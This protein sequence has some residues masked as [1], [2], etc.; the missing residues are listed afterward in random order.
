[1]NFADIITL[2]LATVLWF[3]VCTILTVLIHETGHLVFGKVSGYRLT[4]FA[5]AGLMIRNGRVQKY[6]AKRLSFGQCFMC[7][8]NIEQDPGK[9]IAGGCI[10]N[11]I[12]GS[13]L[14]IAAVITLELGNTGGVWRLM[15]IS[16]PALI[17]IVMGLTNLCGGSPMSDGNTLKD[18]REPGG[19]AMYN[20][21]MVI[22]AHIL[23]GKAFSEMPEELFK[24][25]GNKEKCS[26]TAELSMY[27]YY[28][29]FEKLKDLDGF[30]KLM[31]RHGFDRKPEH[32][33]IFAEEEDL[34]RKIW[35]YVSGGGSQYSEI[36][37]AD[38]KTPRE[39]LVQ[40][41]MSRGSDKKFEDAASVLGS[42]MYGLARS[43]L[44][45]RAALDRV[46]KDKRERGRE[47]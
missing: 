36:T 22:T 26:L 21:I 7:C 20:R 25:S 24:W 29:S 28:R 46:M 42:P 34:E 11:L 47:K 19:K 32:E 18:V 6:P 5:V 30:K 45:S 43:A 44:L 38:A 3:A 1:M 2:A 14:L 8:D 10:T 31:M 9:L 15:L 37:E 12:L 35:T 41:M 40:F 39:V 17:N 23:E 27:G 33:P 13:V 4:G 16:V